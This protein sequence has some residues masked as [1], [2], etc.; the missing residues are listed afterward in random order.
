MLVRNRGAATPAPTSV[1]TSGG[2]PV[3]SATS[4][5]P[6][7][8]ALASDAVAGYLNAVAAGDADA[9]LRRRAPVPAGKF[10]TDQVLAAS[11]KRAP[12]TQIS[13]PDV[14]DPAAST[15]SASYRVG[16]TPVTV[17]YGVQQVGGVWKLTACTRPSTSAWSAPRRSRSG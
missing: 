14:E 6:P 10:M 9:A 12:I 8:P 15:V 2:G 16:K 4:A 5:P 1:P 11:A 13:V 17:D 3:P 7:A